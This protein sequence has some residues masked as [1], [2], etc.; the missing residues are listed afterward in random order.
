MKENT[1]PICGKNG[2]PDFESQDVVCP[3]C[4]SDLSVYRLVNEIELITQ[5]SHKNSNKARRAFV[6]T[7]GTFCVVLLVV[8]GIGIKKL[9]DY[10]VQLDASKTAQTALVEENQALKESLSELQ[11]QVQQPQAVQNFKYVVRKG[12]SFWS[13]SR[14]LYG[15]GC[16]YKEIADANN[17]EVTT[18]LN[19]GD[20]LIIK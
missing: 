10:S 13:I 3:C 7:L 19:I 20:E 11:V 8:A 9:A 18:T 2:I 12:D 15:T 16:R 14:K 6:Y 17:L 5:S 1:C 4:S